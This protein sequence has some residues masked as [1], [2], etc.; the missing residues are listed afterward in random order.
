MDSTE[1][2]R[3]RST[4]PS[5]PGSFSVAQQR[6]S[7]DISDEESSRTPPSKSINRTD[8]TTSN[9]A[10][11][12]APAFIRN[13][14]PTLPGMP[15]RNSTPLKLFRFASTETFFNF[16]PAPQCNRSPSIS[17]LENSGD[18][19]QITT[20]RNPPSRTSRFEPR[21]RMKNLISFSPQ[22]FT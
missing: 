4:A 10:P 16:T 17:I 14:P 22:N 2:G 20:P 7:T 21:P 18:A 15:S 3:P 9:V 11:P 19:K 5:A 1:Y 13:A 12:I 6:Y 8:S